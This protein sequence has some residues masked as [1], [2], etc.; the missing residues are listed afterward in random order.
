M[1]LEG[2]VKGL[3]G[4]GNS[5]TMGEGDMEALV[6]PT[7]RFPLGAITAVCVTQAKLLVSSQS[8]LILIQSFWS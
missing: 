5:P 7:S 2:K 6:E 4:G 3:R 1:T 8:G